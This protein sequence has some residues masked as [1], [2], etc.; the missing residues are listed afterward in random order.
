VDNSSY[1]YK[2]GI[3]RERGW[4]PRDHRLSF[5]RRMK[6]EPGERSTKMKIT[7]IGQV[8]RTLF[9]VSAYLISSLACLL[10]GW[11]VSAFP[12]MPLVLAE[13]LLWSSAGVSCIASLAVTVFAALRAQRWLSG[14][15]S[16]FQ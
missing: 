4:L 13:I 14:R 9:L 2:I 1:V 16:K 7:K 15:M 8:A 5:P 10:V 11:L 6:R 12:D 3:R